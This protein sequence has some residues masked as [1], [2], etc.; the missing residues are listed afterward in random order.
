MPGG[1]RVFAGVLVWRAVTAQR[2][3][4][5]LTSPQVDPLRSDLHAFVTL[6]ALRLFDR[7]GRVEMRTASVRHYSVNL[8]RVL[9]T[10]NALVTWGIERCLVFP[11]LPMV[12]RDKRRLM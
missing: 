7:C 1:V 11:P 3:A 6:A 9:R 4:A 12:W 8:F 5:G 10:R 2:D